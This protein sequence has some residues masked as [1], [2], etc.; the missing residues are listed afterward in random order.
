MFRLFQ[1]LE[2]ESV[3]KLLYC[4][5]ALHTSQYLLELLVVQMNQNNNILSLLELEQPNVP[6]DGL[7]VVYLLSWTLAMLVETVVNHPRGNTQEN[8]LHFVA[9]IQC[10]YMFLIN[11]DQTN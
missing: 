2:L 11:L 10:Y 5:M 3:N 6:Q 1:Y 4:S 7:M 9:N 8:G